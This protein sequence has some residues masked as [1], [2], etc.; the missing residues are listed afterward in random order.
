VQ[1]YSISIHISRLMIIWIYYI[2]CR[3]PILAGG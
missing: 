2:W 3:Y 1:V